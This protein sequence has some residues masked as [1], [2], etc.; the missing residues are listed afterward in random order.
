M[1]GGNWVAAIVAGLM[2]L[3]LPAGAGKIKRFT[4]EEGILHIVEGEPG[5]AKPGAGGATSLGR[6]PS[7]PYPGTPGPA[8]GPVASPVIQTPPAPSTSAEAPAVPPPP[9]SPPE[10][11][12]GDEGGDGPEETD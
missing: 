4:D 7:F 8:G 11:E 9:P 6:P 10:P 12:A 1:G 5:E 3:A 2:L